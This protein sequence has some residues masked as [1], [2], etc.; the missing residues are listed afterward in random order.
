MMYN[1]MASSY[2]MLSFSNNPSA[3]Y[4]P[5]ASSIPVEYTGSSTLDD[6]DRRRR[7]TGVAKD[8]ENVPNM[9]LV[10]FAPNPILIHHTVA[11]PVCSA[12]EHRIV[13]LNGRFENGKRSM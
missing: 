12:V 1:N 2:D 8:K 7:K 9:H 5:Q 3:Y 13:P 6:R 10:G 11:D 4:S